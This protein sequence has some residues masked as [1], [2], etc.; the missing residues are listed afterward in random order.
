MYGGQSSCDLTSWQANWA[1][2]NLV[3]FQ[4]MLLQASKQALTK[5]AR[6]MGLC[7]TKA[8]RSS[9]AAAE[10][11]GCGMRWGASAAQWNTM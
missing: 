3:V 6:L 8:R 11:S 7:P 9:P 5:A 2:C 10:S 4:L 1:T